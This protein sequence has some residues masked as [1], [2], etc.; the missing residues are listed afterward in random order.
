MLKIYKF[1]TNNGDWGGIHTEYTIAENELDAKSQCKY[2]LQ[3]MEDGCDGWITEI[4]GEKLLDIL[5]MRLKNLYE[6]DFTIKKR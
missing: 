5:D 3:R 1:V 2:S 4:T 6:I